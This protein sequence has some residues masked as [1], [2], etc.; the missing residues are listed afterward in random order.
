MNFQDF[1]S[2]L[3]REIKL[4]EVNYLPARPGGGTNLH[5]HFNRVHITCVKSGCGICTVNEHSWKL[6][7]GTV[8]VVVPG[9]M[10]AYSSDQHDP[11]KIYFLHFD[12]FGKMLDELPR[13]MIIPRNERKDFFLQV[14]KLSRLY[15]SSSTSISEFHKYGLILTI[16]GELIRFAETIAGES[17]DQNMPPGGTEKKLNIIM[18][19]LYGPPFT[20]PGIDDLSERSGMSRRTL[21]NLFQEKNGMPIKQYYLRNVMNYAESIIAGGE[22]KVSDLAL[23]CGFSNSQNFLFAYKRFLAKKQK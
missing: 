16:I 9:E 5:A 18:Q 10:H 7:P 8:H 20:F 22:I 13:R 3:G 23:Q 14:E 2:R 11:Y 15:S 21:I 6:T 19:A 1:I 12:W 17:L 4:K